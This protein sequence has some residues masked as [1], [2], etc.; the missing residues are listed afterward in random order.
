M[1]EQIVELE[2]AF[3][4]LKQNVQTEKISKDSVLPQDT[5]PAVSANYKQALCMVA[6]PLVVFDCVNGKVRVL[7]I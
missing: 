5:E 7:Y 2:G 1:V 4:N 6:Q 3:F